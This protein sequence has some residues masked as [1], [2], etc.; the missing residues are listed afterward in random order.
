M[1]ASRGAI[2]NKKSSPT[3]NNKKSRPTRLLCL[4][5]RRFWYALRLSN[6]KYFLRR[7]AVRSQKK[8][9]PCFG[10]LAPPLVG[11]DQPCSRFA[12]GK[13]AEPAIS[14]AADF[15]IR[16]TECCSFLSTNE[17][18]GQALARRRNTTREAIGRVTPSSERWDHAGRRNRPRSTPGIFTTHRK[19]HSSQIRRKRHGTARFQADSRPSRDSSE[20]FRSG[21]QAHGQ[22]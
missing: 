10:L 3:L 14:L 8:P 2:K 11:L 7:R 1:H 18:P 13:P 19:R 4:R 6:C 12:D 21:T 15:V 17:A 22:I 16:F 9:R 5:Q 20:Q